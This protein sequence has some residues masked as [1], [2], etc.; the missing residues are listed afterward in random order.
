[1]IKEIEKPKVKELEKLIYN[2][3]VKKNTNS[4][5][6]ILRIQNDD[7]FTRIDFIYYPKSYY[8]NGGWVQI[9][10]DTFIRP[11]G[12]NQ[13]LKLIKA[14]NIP[15]APTKHFF[16]NSK[17][18]LCYTLYFPSL[19]K[20]T[21]SIDIIENEGTHEETWFNFYGV[22]MERVLSEKLVAGN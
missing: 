8:V 12:S 4:Q 11:V 10:R 3:L 18:F 16:K 7:N 14:I 17:E 6:E 21:S 5:P 15:L 13:R 1:M 19:P 9:D 22:S 20:E 2:P